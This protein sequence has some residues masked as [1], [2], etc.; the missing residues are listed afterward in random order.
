MTGCSFALSK[1]PSFRLIAPGG[2]TASGCEFSRA[3]S[4]VNRG[5]DVKF[6]PSIT[7]RVSPLPRLV[8]ATIPTTAGQ[9]RFR[10]AVE[11]RRVPC[12]G[13]T[14]KSMSRYM[15][16]RNPAAVRKCGERVGFAWW[17]ARNSGRRCMCARIFSILIHVLDFRVR[18]VFES[19][20]F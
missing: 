12:N 4:A 15:Y 11:A 7:T 13:H 20:P 19:V 3:Y 8:V 2:S 6:N 1:L 18:D 16:V 10:K 17:M 9:H 5:D 14:S